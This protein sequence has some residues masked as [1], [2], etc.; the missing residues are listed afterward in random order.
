MS[1]PMDT[2][3]YCRR[4][5]PCIATVFGEHQDAVADLCCDCRGDLNCEDCA[6]LEHGELLS[7]EDERYERAAAYARGNDFAATDGRDWT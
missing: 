3:D 6:R 7:D 4:E 5:M 2:C 1:R